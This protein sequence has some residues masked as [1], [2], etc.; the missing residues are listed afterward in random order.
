MGYS[1]Y[2]DPEEVPITKCKFV[3]KTPAA[4]FKVPVEFELKDLELP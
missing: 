2:F 4:L 1:Y 3:Y